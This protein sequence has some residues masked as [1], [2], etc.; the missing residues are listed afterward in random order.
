MDP[1]PVGPAVPGWTTRPRPARATIAGR[2]ARVEPLDP[3]RHGPEIHAAN[4]ADPGAMWTWLPY[5]PFPSLAAWEA[6]AVPFAA[7]EDPLA[8]AIVDAATGRAGGVATLMS[9]VP[10]HGTIEIG[11]IALAPVLRRTRVAT[12]GLLVLADAAFRLGYRRL[13]WKCDSRNAPSRA[14]ALRLGF[15][16]EG[17]FR[18]HR[19]VKGHNRDT[20]WYAITDAE[21]P[22]LAAAHARWL[23]PASFHP[24]GT[25]R[26]RLSVLTAAARATLGDAEP[27]APAE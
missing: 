27:G 5:G 18:S 19:V 25:A 11:N 8:F 10:E 12:E 26:E 9:I 21:W 4:A 20:S 3:A 14:A 7:T 6:W 15:R 23:D 16:Y 17:T 22:A 1:L 2:W 13:E 24:D